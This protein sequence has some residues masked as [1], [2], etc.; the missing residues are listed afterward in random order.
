MARSEGK[1]SVIDTRTLC[2]ELRELKTFAADCV[3]PFG[4]RNIQMSS[5]PTDTTKIVPS[6]IPNGST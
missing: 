6:T 5:E 1:A 2:T 3:E 4:T